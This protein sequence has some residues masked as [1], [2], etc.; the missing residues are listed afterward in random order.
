METK[1]ITEH[2]LYTL[3]ATISLGGSLL[4]SASTIA[5]IAKQDAWLSG[6]ITIITGIPVTLLL[7][8]LGSRYPGMTLIGIVKKIF[9]KWLGYAVSIAYLMF[10]VTISMHVPWYIGSFFGRAMSE[11][12]FYVIQTLCVAGVVIAVFY[13]IEVIA[14]ASE[15]LIMFVSIF[16]VLFIVLTLKDIKPEYITPI[17]EDG[18]FPAIKGSWFLSTYITFAQI[19]IMMIFPRHTSDMTKAR[20]ALVKGFLWSGSISF[21]TTLITTLVLGYSLTMR[22]TLPSLYL[23]MSISIGAVLTR[24]EYVLSLIWLATQFMVAVSF[25]YSAVIGLAELLGLKDHKKI[26]LPYG[27]LV[28]IMSGVVLP[29]PVYQGNWVNTV[30]TPLSTTFG[31]IIPVI[32]AVVYLIK[33]RL[34]AQL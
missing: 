8:F 19:S 9:G 34:Y 16:F 23:S 17:L 14:R 25:F 27:L 15:M 1:K 32:M 24:L 10:F 7:Y 29:N 12:P 30:Y 3:T 4:V 26:V 2:Q 11:T 22:L 6:L 5:S 31:L 13:G 20:K 21:I 18:L 33:K 28:L